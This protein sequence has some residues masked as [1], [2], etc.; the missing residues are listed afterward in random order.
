MQKQINLLNLHIAKKNTYDK[1]GLARTNSYEVQV[2]QNKDKGQ[3]P[4]F[5]R[6]KLNETNRKGAVYEYRD[7]RWA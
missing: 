7:N 2:S 1:L 4:I 6:W 3:M 5:L